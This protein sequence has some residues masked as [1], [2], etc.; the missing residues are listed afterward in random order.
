[1][2]SIPLNTF[3]FVGGLVAMLLMY[4]NT[5]VAETYSC[6]DDSGIAAKQILQRSEVSDG[7]FKTLNYPVE[8][9]LNVLDEGDGYLIL[10]K[11]S[12]GTGEGFA[13]ILHINKK[14]LEAQSGTFYGSQ[15][16]TNAR[17]NWTCE[18][19]S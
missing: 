15:Q 3:I 13:H 6:S 2:K 19:S 1:M 10:A 18:V 11:T 17:I 5:A 9:I 8:I 4:T 12:E 16:T 14:T 7:L